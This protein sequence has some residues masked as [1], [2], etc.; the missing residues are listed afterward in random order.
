MNPRYGCQV[1][2]LNGLATCE[3]SVD[4]IGLGKSLEKRILINYFSSSIILYFFIYLYCIFFYL[5]ISMTFLVRSLM[6]T[7]F[8]FFFFGFFDILFCVYVFF[9]YYLVF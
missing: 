6:L 1:F 3:F 7:S 4:Y 5:Y 8:L 2:G 9:S